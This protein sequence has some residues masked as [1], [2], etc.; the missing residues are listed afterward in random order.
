MTIINSNTTAVPGQFI[1]LLRQLKGAKQAVVAKKLGIT[2]QALSKMENCKKV[3][4]EKIQVVIKLL[5]FSDEDIE[6]VKK[7]LPAAGG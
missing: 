5:N 1:R 7:L 3:H 2:Q 6:S 4:N